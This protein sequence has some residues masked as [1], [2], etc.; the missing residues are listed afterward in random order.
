MKNIISFTL[1][2]L[3]PIIFFGQEVKEHQTKINE[4][5][6][7]KGA[8]IRFEDLKL[9]NIKSAYEFA[10]SRIRKIEI[11]DEKGLFLQISISGKYDT[12][13]SSISYEDLIEIQN[14]MGVLQKLAQNDLS[15]ELDYIENKYTTK[16]EFI[17][18]YYV[19]KN[20][21]NWYMKI[22]GSSLFSKN[23]EVFQQAFN[24][25]KDKMESLK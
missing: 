17:I 25:A 22:E 3:I 2:L 8:I 21:L 10:E 23:S 16:D 9:P 11:S 13:T 14:A 5:I 15:T 24:L 6:S 4:F 20:K 12:K 19:S 7:K 1:P 18:G